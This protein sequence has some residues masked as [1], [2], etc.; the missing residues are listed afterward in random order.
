MD[1][2]LELARRGR[3]G[4]LVV[5]PVL[6][7]EDDGWRRELDALGVSVHEGVEGMV[8]EFTD[9]VTV[10]VLNPPSP[11]LVGTAS[12]VDN[13]GLV[14]R[15]RLGEAALLFTG[16]LFEGGERLMLERGAD[17][18][19]AVLKLGHHGS[20]TSTGAAFL[21]A[22]SPSIAVVSAGAE[23]T[24]GHP[25]AL[26]IERVG[27]YAGEGRIFE[28]ARQGTIEVT[29]DGSTWWVATERD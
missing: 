19:A 22:V 18:G 2:L 24:L 28:T 6:P 21:A 5:P 14:L 3:I 15:V 12:D 16:D 4:R 26:V 13:N 29:T 7:G 10:E 1:G 27:G 11:P 9:G 23:N 8:V 25:S 20:E 17:V